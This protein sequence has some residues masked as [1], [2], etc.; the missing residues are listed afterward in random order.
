MQKH[1]TLYPRKFDFK[2]GHFNALGKSA[3]TGAMQHEFF[4]ETVRNTND[5]DEWIT[6]VHKDNKYVYK[7]VLRDI[8][9]ARAKGM[10]W[11]ILDSIKEN[12]NS[13]KHLIN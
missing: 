9:G 8:G 2:H 1:E 7:K 6:A 10:H 11:D 12:N 13:I 5:P 4:I 3:K